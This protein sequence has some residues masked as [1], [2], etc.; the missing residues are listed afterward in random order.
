MFHKKKLSLSIA[1]LAALGASYTATAVAQDDELEE[2]VVTGIRGS[3]SKA[4]DMKRENNQIVDAIVAEDIGKFPDNNVIEAMSHITGVQVGVDVKGEGSSVVIRGSGDVVTTIN[5]QQVFTGV[6][7]GMALQDVPATLVAGIEV[8]KSTSADMIEGGVGG[9]VNVRMRRA[10]DFDGSKVAVA[11]K[12]TYNDQ[13]DEIDPN[14]SALVSNRWDTS[15]GEFGA[16]LNVAYMESNYREEAV[17]GGGFF[18]YSD[19]G[20]PIGG[21]TPGVALDTSP[22][23][24]YVLMRDAAGAWDR[25]G[26]NKRPAVNVSLQWAPSDSL[27]TYLDASYQGYEGKGN[28]SFLFTR[29]DAQQKPGTEYTYHPGTNVVKTAQTIN[30]FV[31]TS[32]Q[33]Y[34]SETESMQYTTGANWDVNDKLNI[35]ADLN[36]QTSTFDNTGLILDLFAIAPTLDVDFNQNG[37]VSL[38]YGTD[39]LNR[40]EGVALGTFFDGWTHSKGTAYSAKVDADYSVEL[41][42]IDKF[43]FGVR[44]SS[45]N[46]ENQDVQNSGC[47]C[48]ET[49]VTDPRLDGILDYTPGDFM[50]GVVTFPRQWLTPSVDWMLDSGNQDT[51]R[52]IV[53]FNYTGKP[54]YDPTRYFDIT[55]DTT[56]LYGQ[57]HY[58]FEVAGKE[59][60][61]LVGTRVVS[62]S[63]ELNGFQIDAN[64]GN[65]ASPVSLNADD[66]V[67]LPNAS[68]RIQL[69]DTL[70]GR[71]NGSQTLTRPA[72]GDLN[73]A[74]T[75]RAPIA[76]QINQGT[77]SGGNPNLEPIVATNFDV[78]LE[79]YFAED[80]ALTATVFNRNFTD[81]I[82]RKTTIVDVDGVPY[83]LDRPENSGESDYTGYEVGFQYFPENL[84]AVLQGLGIQSSYTYIDGELRPESGAAKTELFNVSKESYSAALAYEKNAFSARIS[85][86]YRD[87]FKGGE[88]F[89]CSM[90]SD[91]MAQNYGSTDV[92][93][94][95]DITDDI[96]VTLDATN[97]FGDN[98]Q[99][100]FGDATLFNRDTVRF[101]KTV[102][103]GVRASF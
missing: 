66:T 27:E 72:F 102:S 92:S 55:E 13:S 29:T 1:M 78:A 41:G 47:R 7:R 3:L 81:T 45:R 58:V 53:G 69:T 42:A 87:A 51:L 84:P 64:N 38:D 71:I 18:P 67:A 12:G 62:T 90:P 79:W 82:V 83:R 9:V 93:V 40:T 15:A 25:Y 103:A 26:L 21:S 94:S 101:A 96:I 50:D 35:K 61:G 88:N 57:F 10:F 56:A 14:V 77:G 30:A 48:W 2:V 99:D 39:N 98:F 22:N 6:G 49:A 54:A 44:Y 8:F 24:D 86:V 95:Y 85:Y 91:I 74:L 63:S 20:V 34:E 23:N 89:C 70:T 4:L 75:L 31:L 5:G 68:M 37:A 43:E 19:A 16:L 59:I 36:Y 32:T 17:W 73:P 60:D 97:I 80:S 28:M 11:A 100:Y 52:S 76:G 46:A 65:A 33:A